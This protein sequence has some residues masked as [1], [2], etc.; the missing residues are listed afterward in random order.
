MAYSFPR[1]RKPTTKV[2]YTHGREYSMRYKLHK[3]VRE[4]YDNE[5]DDDEDALTL[6]SGLAD[7]SA[8]T[9]ASYTEHMVLHPRCHRA[10]PPLIYLCPVATNGMLKFYFVDF[11]YSTFPGKID[12]SFLFRKVDVT[13]RD[14]HHWCTTAISYLSITVGIYRH[15]RR[16]REGYIYAGL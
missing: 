13:C 2:A 16:R 10:Q 7:A 5:D 14:L 12:S 8:V 15:G 11:T 4:N 9:F 1:G 3:Y 6:G